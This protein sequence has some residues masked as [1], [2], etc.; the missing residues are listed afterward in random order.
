[1]QREAFWNEFTHTGDS[2]ARNPGSHSAGLLPLN[3]DLFEDPEKY[4]QVN[5][6]GQ[7]TL[8]F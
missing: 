5:I 8:I 2:S 3:T 7:R 6:Q 4:L 1:M